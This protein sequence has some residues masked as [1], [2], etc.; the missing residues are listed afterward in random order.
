M[1]DRLP[2]MERL[3][4]GLFF[5]IGI[6]MIAIA[7]ADYLSGGVASTFAFWAPA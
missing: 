7:A 4:P 1:F 5:L 2:T 3:A 6:A